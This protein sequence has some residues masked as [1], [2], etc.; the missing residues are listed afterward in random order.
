DGDGRDAARRRAAT[1]AA[2]G[3]GAVRLSKHADVPAGIA[4]DEAPRNTRRL[5]ALQATAALLFLALAAQLLHMQVLDPA[6]PPDV[7]GEEFPKVV[8]REAPRGLILD[9]DGRVIAENVP[10]FSLVVVPGD[11]PQDEAE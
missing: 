9:R 10:Q 5:L 4:T 3:A 8:K 7:D 2:P 11:L 1:A 6:S